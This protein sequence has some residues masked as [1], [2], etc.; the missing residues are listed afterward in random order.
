MSRW[1]MFVA[2]VLLAVVIASGCEPV[3]PPRF[4]R[5]EVCAV[6]ITAERIMV[7]RVY[8]DS[9][10]YLCRVGG[11]RQRRRDGIVSA[12]TEIARYTMILFYDFELEKIG[13]GGTKER[14]R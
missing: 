1:R 14:Q 12:D 2:A 8:Y 6:K 11:A 10:K 3:E 7:M 13:D 4:R 9:P 5:G